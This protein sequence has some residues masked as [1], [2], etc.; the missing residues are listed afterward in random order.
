MWLETS[1]NNLNKVFEIVDIGE[2][3]SEKMGKK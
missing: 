3:F 1:I 2:D